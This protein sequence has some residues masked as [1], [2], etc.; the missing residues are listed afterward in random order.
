MKVIKNMIAEMKR[1]LTMQGR[2]E[3][4]CLHQL[5]AVRQLGIADL[6]KL[7]VFIIDK[8]YN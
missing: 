4:N 1:L 8:R 3:P 7:C 2:N 5:F 6:E